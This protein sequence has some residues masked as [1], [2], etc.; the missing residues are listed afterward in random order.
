[1]EALAP[2][3]GLKLFTKRGSEHITIETNFRKLSQTNG[4]IDLGG[5]LLFPVKLN[6]LHQ[7]SL[8]LSI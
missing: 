2:E 7:K 3:E 5:F 4:K 1:M 6:I 8:L